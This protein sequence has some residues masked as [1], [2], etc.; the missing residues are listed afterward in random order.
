MKTH[1]LGRTGLKVSE[2]TVLDFMELAFL[3]KATDEHLD[4]KMVLD[5]RDPILDL[6]VPN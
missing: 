2:G 1:R 6:I 5:P 3:K 4:H